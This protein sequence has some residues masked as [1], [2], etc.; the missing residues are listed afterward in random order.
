MSQTSTYTVD[1]MTCAHCVASVQE[2]VAEV[3]GVSD[4]D[5]DLVSRR[6]VVTAVGPIDDGAI[7]AAVEEAGYRLE[8]TGSTP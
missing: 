8:G 7:R 4:V 6:L 5:V 2:E 1:G 3:A